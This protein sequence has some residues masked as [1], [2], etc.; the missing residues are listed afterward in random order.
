MA[1]TTRELQSDK[2][3]RIVDAMRSSVGVR[4]AAGSTFD[5]VAREAGVSRGLLHYYFGTKERLL[6]EVCRRDC[7]IR[8]EVFDEAFAA[9][10][11]ADE[12]IDALV[13]SLEDLVESDPGFIALVFELFTSSRHNEEIRAGLHDLSA[14]V[15][16]HLAEQLVAAETAGKIRLGAGPDAIAAILFAL[17]D[18]LAL[19]MLSEDERDW[20]PTLEAG[21]LAVRQLLLPTA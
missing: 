1:T 5:H 8:M 10:A 13:H 3:Q 16:E 12:L 9:S 20:T 21:A 15:R 18:G 2:A 6:V 19:R 17:A 4:G 7:D 14:R 11:G